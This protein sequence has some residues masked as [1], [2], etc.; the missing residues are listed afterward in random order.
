MAREQF[1]NLTE[2]MY[3]ILLALTRECCGVDIMEMV[4]QISQGRVKV[5]PG[6]LYTLLAKFEEAK[7]IKQTKIEGRKRSYIITEKGM[8]L[9]RDEYDR[10]LILVNE[11]KT[12]LE[13]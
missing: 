3:Y 4:S 1:Q 5:G 8:R 10:L 7:I 12:F 2:P 11:G 9:L 13:D 6:T